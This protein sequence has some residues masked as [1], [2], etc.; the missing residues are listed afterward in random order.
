[1]AVKYP[2]DCESLDPDLALKKVG[3][4]PGTEAMAKFGELLIKLA[5]GL[6]TAP[7]N[8]DEHNAYL[9]N[10]GGL[11]IPDG[12]R[13][14]LIAQG[15]DNIKILIPPKELIELAVCEMQKKDRENTPTYEGLPAAYK[16]LDDG[17]WTDDGSTMERFYEVRV[18]DYTIGYC[19]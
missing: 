11:E 13:V 5:L 4:Q 7:L 16:Q 12:V 15:V 6:E 14:E 17:T 1:M 18:C 2:I 19:R 10:K 8:P 9:K 3:T